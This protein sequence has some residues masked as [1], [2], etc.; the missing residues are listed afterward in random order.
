MVLS[1]LVSIMANDELSPG[2]SHAKEVEVCIVLI[3]PFSD[4]F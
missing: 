2:L 1:H 4:L 3:S